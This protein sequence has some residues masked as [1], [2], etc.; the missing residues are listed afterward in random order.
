MILL[1][2][3]LLMLVWLPNIFMTSASS[4]ATQG[5]YTP[6]K[7]KYACEIFKKC[8][9]E[10]NLWH[11]SALK[12][13]AE[14]TPSLKKNKWA[15][16]RFMG[17]RPK[18]GALFSESLNFN[19]ESM[20]KLFVQKSKIETGLTSEKCARGCRNWNICWLKKLLFK[21]DRLI[22]AQISFKKSS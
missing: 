17:E 15:H 6:G 11:F 1:P 10:R 18:K 2:E 21:S 19:D 20:N 4:V 12:Y 9:S 7:S 3:F 22:K 14:I 5:M 16:Q 8:F 13:M